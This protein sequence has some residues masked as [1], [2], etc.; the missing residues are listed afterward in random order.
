MWAY[1]S[2]IIICTTLRF[3][4]DYPL[5]NAI[6]IAITTSSVF[7]AIEDLFS[8]LSS[9]LGS[10]IDIAEN[11]LFESKE[12]NNKDLVFF[13][14]VDKKAELY[15]GSKNDIT[16]IKRS[17]DSVKVK[18]K[19]MEQELIDFEEGLKIKKKAKTKLR[20]TA[21]IFA[22][23]G[24]L[25]LLCVMIFTSNVNLSPL[26]QDIFT[27]VPFVTILI[28][29]QINTKASVLIKKEMSES[30]TVLLK[31]DEV[32]QSLLG[33]EEKFNYLINLIEESEKDSEVM[34]YA[35]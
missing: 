26:V 15:S 21:N 1:I 5:W 25:C 23:L 9:S 11:F 7:F 13:E 6:V 17:F 12:K 31:Q 4:V 30:K 18:A 10:S 29:Q 20:K 34:N 22:Y 14:Q 32:R 24:F 2:F 19:E 27:V 28:T 3:I 35:D 33:S 8:S 16:S